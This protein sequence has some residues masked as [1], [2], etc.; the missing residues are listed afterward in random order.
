M[1]NYQEF[2]KDAVAAKILSTEVPTDVD[3]DTFISV[4][5]TNIIKANNATKAFSKISAVIEIS[6]KIKICTNKVFTIRSNQPLVKEW[7]KTDIGS[8]YESII[9]S[10]DKNCNHDSADRFKSFYDQKALSPITDSWVELIKIYK[11]AIPQYEAKTVIL[12]SPEFKK[13]I[14]KFSS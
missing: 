13:I 6:R 9:N 14:K 7:F 10:L 2:K 8:K 4:I 12:N 5:E 3:W 11:D 1:S